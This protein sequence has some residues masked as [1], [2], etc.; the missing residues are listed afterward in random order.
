[1]S[2]AGIIWLWFNIIISDIKLIAL[3][4]QNAASLERN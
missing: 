3:P 4:Y 2:N 1:M